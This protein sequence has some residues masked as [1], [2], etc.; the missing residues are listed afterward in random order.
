[1]LNKH[2]SY[3]KYHHIIIIDCSL[4]YKKIYTFFYFLFFFGGCWASTKHQSELLL[5]KTNQHLL[6]NQN[7]AFN[8]A[9]SYENGIANDRQFICM[10]YICVC[11]DLWSW[12]ICRAL[13][14]SGFGRRR[15]GPG[16]ESES[17]WSHSERTDPLP[18]PPLQSEK[19]NTQ[20]DEIANSDIYTV[21]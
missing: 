6:S 19:R 10:E 17:S 21:H 9:M 8:G 16:R 5:K 2:S 13:W 1:M 11:T 18:N 12:A 20:S 15:S 7:R 4:L 3:Q 14:E